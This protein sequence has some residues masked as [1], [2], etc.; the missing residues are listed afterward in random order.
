MSKAFS[1]ICL[2]VVMPASGRKKPKWSGKSVIGAGD[3]LAA[4]QVFGLEVRRRRSRG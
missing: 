2:T 3:G 4:R 1:R